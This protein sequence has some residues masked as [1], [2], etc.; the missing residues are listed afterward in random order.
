L[1]KFLEQYQID[2]P[3]QA[4][5]FEQYQEEEFNRRWTAGGIEFVDTND[6]ATRTEIE[7]RVAKMADD[8]G[9]QV[10]K[11]KMVCYECHEFCGQMVTCRCE[12]MIGEKCVLKHA[13]ACGPFKEYMKQHGHMFFQHGPDAYPDKPPFFIHRA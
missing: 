4:Q 7:K 1:I 3:E 2:D 9:V 5:R 12:A 6:P 8:A 11:V 13:R 10:G